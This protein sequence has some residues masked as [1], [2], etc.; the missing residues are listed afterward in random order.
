MNGK[1]RVIRWVKLESKYRVKQENEDIPDANDGD[2]TH[3][4]CLGAWPLGDL[5]PDER[6]D[7]WH[8]HSAN[9][10]RRP[11]TRPRSIQ[12]GII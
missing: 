10:R 8:P 1:A 4:N 6:E 11:Y 5:R 7:F 3:S 12:G 9:T 2:P